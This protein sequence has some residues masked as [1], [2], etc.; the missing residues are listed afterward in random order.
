MITTR[1]RCS[2]SVPDL[3]VPALRTAFRRLRLAALFAVL[4]V[5]VVSHGCHGEDV[6]DELLAPPGAEA[7]AGR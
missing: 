5:L 2:G 3:P 1:R 6:D 4:G 7:G